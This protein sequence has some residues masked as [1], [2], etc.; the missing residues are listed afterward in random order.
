MFAMKIFNKELKISREL[1]V[2]ILIFGVLAGGLVF[3]SGLGNKES[4]QDLE[5]FEEAPLVEVF[6]LAAVISRIDGQQNTIFV[7]HPTE[8]REIKVVFNGGT[9]IFRVEFPFDPKNPPREMVFSP[10]LTK[11]T[12]DD[13]KPGN[14]A[15]IETDKNIYQKSEFDDVKRIQ[16][17]P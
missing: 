4:I 9:E 12:I 14:Q 17:L 16:V 3:F 8:P 2:L 11:I 10:K 1:F 5:T 6:N 13:L 15:L 7:N